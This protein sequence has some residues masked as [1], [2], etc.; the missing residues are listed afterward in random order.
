MSIIE[1]QNLNYSVK[2]F[3]ILEN[4]SFSLDEGEVLGITART[5]AGKSTLLKLLAGFLKPRSGD[6]YINLFNSKDYGPAYLS[7]WVSIVFQ[8]PTEEIFCKT[9]YDELAF[10]LRQAKA[11]DY[12]VESMVGRVAALMELEDKLK[13]DPM[14]LSYTDKRLLTIG[15]E[16]VCDFDILLLDEPMSGL[17]WDERRIVFKV[18]EELQK[19][20]KTLVIASN[21]IEFLYKASDK[22]L[23]LD[24][25]LGH[26]FGSKEE[27]FREEV[28]SRTGI[29]RPR[30]N[31]LAK[32]VLDLEGIYDIDS[33]INSIKHW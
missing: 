24:N 30:L 14:N 17:D 12:Y 28:L 32:D 6:V 15:S 29:K 26:F 8:N 25:D 3:K 13:D 27:V 18:I 19:E 7:K 11:P 23:I 16:L 31:S 22:I 20:S 2:G 1:V 4:L 5:G 10:A 9:V 33:F 21:D